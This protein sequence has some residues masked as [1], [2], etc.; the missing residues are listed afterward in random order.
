LTF[1][2]QSTRELYYTRL[3]LNVQVGCTSFEDIRT[4]DGQVFDSYREA[5]GALGLLAND[6]EFIDAIAEM[7]LICSESYV[8]RMFARLLLCC[9]L[10]DPRNV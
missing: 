10:T 6:R 9:S 1:V 4:V 3:L 7:D 2:P 5:C 8:R